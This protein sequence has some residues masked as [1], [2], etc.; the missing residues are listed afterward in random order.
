MLLSRRRPGGVFVWQDCSVTPGTVINRTLFPIRGSGWEPQESAAAGGL[1]PRGAA[2][3]G[4]R[5]H[6]FKG[7]GRGG[8]AA[9]A[10]GGMGMT[11][12]GVP[13]AGGG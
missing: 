13:V 7:T 12:N 2:L 8:S 4:G 9:Q 6:R 10:V 3:M 5:G 1:W 11:R